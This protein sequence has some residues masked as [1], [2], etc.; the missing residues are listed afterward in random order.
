MR[1]AD[2]TPVRGLFTSRSAPRC[3]VVG[4]LP[5]APA[6]CGAATTFPK[7]ANRY[8]PPSFFSGNV[9]CAGLSVGK[10]LAGR[11]GQRLRAEGLL[12]AQPLVPL[13]HA[14]RAREAAHLELGNPPADREVHDRYV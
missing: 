4:F 10:E 5:S 7:P 3:R 8:G 6:G 1:F 2:G 12:D 13:R 9:V 11:V 14:L